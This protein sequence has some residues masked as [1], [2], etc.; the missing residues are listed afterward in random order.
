M[1]SLFKKSNAE[2]SSMHVLSFSYN[3]FS[4]LIIL[5]ISVNF[6]KSVIK[7]EL[8]KV[9]IVKEVVVKGEVVNGTV[10]TVV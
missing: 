1:H 9:G 8:V 6:S 5:F 10:G 7:G 2:H 3:A 4:Q